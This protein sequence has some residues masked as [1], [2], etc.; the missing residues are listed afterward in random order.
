LVPSGSVSTLDGAE[1][2]WITFLVN[3]DYLFMVLGFEPMAWY[4]SI[5]P[6]PPP[7]AFFVFVFTVG[8]HFAQAGIESS[9][10]FFFFRQ[11]VAT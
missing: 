11:G 6:S 3:L 5:T 8:S 1:S 4:C 10:L 2:L 9:Y 7:T